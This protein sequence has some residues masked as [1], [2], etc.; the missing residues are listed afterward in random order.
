MRISNLLFAL[1]RFLLLP[2]L[3]G[4]IYLYLYPAIQN[5]QFPLARP[6]STVRHFDGSTSSP[7][8]AAEI[9]PFRLLAL[10]DPQLEGDTSIPRPRSKEPLWSRL[11]DEGVGPLIKADLGTV[12]QGYRKRVDLWG[13]DLYLAHIYRSVRWWTQPSHTVVLGDLLGSQW[14]G[15]EEFTRRGERFW[16]RVFKHGE[17]VPRSIT[18]V[19]GRFEILGNDDRWKRRIMAV[20]GNHDVGY[21]GDIDEG[22]IGRFEE[23]FGRVNWEIRFRLN[24]SAIPTDSRATMGVIRTQTTPVPELRVVILNTMNLDSPALEPG[25]QQQSLDFLHEHI[26]IIPRAEPHSATVLL[27]HIPLN[28][29]AGVC[30]DAPFFSY[31]PSDQ[32]GGIKEQNHLSPEISRKILDGLARDG[33]AVIL[34]GHDHEGCDTLHTIAESSASSPE[35]SWSASR[36]VPFRAVP[37]NLTSIREIT[38]R[39]MMGSFSGNA[40]LFSA[41][42]DREMGIWR[43]EYDVCVLG[44]QHI[45]WAV[46]VLGLIEVGL[47]VGAVLFAVLEVLYDRKVER[48]RSRIKKSM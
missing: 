6:P 12:L 23:A 36:H 10:G 33:S 29:D 39:S 20:A 47:G 2:A 27:T 25:L 28:K 38:V 7:G 1:F 32:G 9:A 24:D 4:I 19:N 34:N 44:V 15:D 37:A 26:A 5:C 8:A 18:D 14:I 42:F 17:K 30:V 11:R 48:E 21:A 43:F 41:W 45:W 22:R 40:G 13:N 31:F 16:N 35:E 3:I 46:H